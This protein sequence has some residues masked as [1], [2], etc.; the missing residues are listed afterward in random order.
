MQYLKTTQS[1]EQDRLKMCEVVQKMRAC[2]NR[3][4]WRN[5]CMLGI[6]SGLWLGSLT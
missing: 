2:K 5:V 3:A 6:S 1:R 4:I